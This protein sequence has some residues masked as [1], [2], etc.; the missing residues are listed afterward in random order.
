MT[1]ADDRPALDMAAIRAPFL[2]RWFWQGVYV[3]SIIR[4]LAA[5][6]VLAAIG[7]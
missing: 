2:A 7:R 5:T 3:T 4:E 1:L 6:L